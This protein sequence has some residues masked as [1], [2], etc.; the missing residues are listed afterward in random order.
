[1]IQKSTL[2]LFV[3]LAF[4]GYFHP[5]LKANNGAPAPFKSEPDS[6]H[7][8]KGVF[9]FPEITVSPSPTASAT[10]VLTGIEKVIDYDVSPAGPVVAALV[11]TSDQTY[12]IKFWKIGDHSLTDCWTTPAGYVPTAIAWHPLGDEMFVIAIKET[13]YHILRVEK[14]NNKWVSTSIF[15][16][17][18][19]LKRLVVCPRPFVT[20]YNS[21][22]RSEYYSYRIFF[23][24]SL[25]NKSFRTVS[26]TEDGTR[27]YQVIGPRELKTTF[28]DNDIPPSEMTSEYALPLTFH[29]AGHELVWED[30]Q[31]NFNVSNYNTSY[32]GE[33]KPLAPSILKGGSITATPNGLGFIHWRKDQPG[34]G[35]YL[36]TTGKEE[37]QLQDAHLITTP[38]SV[39]DGRGIVGLSKS[40]DQYTF[41]YLPVNMPLADVQNAW[42]FVR[43]SEELNLFQKNFGLFRTTSDDQL[44]QLYE[45]ENYAC[46]GYDRTVPTRPYLVTTDIFWELYASAYEGI[47]IISERDQAIPN[48]W[49]FVGAADQYYKENSKTSPWVPVFQAL[50]DLHSG[51]KQNAEVV[52][53]TEA[54]GVLKSET[55]NKEFNYAELKPRSHYTSNIEMQQYFMGFK[56]LTTVYDTNSTIMEELNQLPPEVQSYAAKWIECYQGFISPSRSPLVWKV[57]K[58]DPPRYNKNPGTNLT[59]FP[60]SWGFDNEVLYSTVYHENTPVELRV[61]G[62]GGMRLL[63]SGLDLA[64][65]LGNGLATSILHDD[66]E[67]YPPLKR[68]IGNL[69]DNFKTQA[70]VNSKNSN[71][72]DCWIN[73]LAIQWADTVRS[74]N[75]NLDKSLWQ[76]KRLQTGLASWATLRHATGLVNERSAAECGEAGFEEIILRAP[77]GYVE[78]DPFTFE[79]IADLFEATIK[80]LPKDLSIAPEIHESYE[81]AKGSLYDG[82]TKRLNEMVKTAR[83]FKVIAEKERNGQMLS[84]E[85]FVQILYIGAIAEHCFLIFK[86]LSNP[87]YAL[88]TPDPMP[89]IADVAGDKLVSYLNAAVGDPLEWDYVIPYYGRHEIV[90]GSVYS[91]YEFNS[92]QLFDDKDWRNRLKTQSFLPWIKPMITEEPLSYP[93]NS[94]Y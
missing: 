65:S 41:S 12:G 18:N 5:A 43:S 13:K 67:K 24:M 42:M 14:Q 10:I 40:G 79:A 94:G 4:I 8:V 38:S 62:P 30:G 16:S 88:S 35:M 36:L 86:S 27:F 82:I 51:N 63:P 83:E 26:T 61:E 48:F 50:S 71:L 17:S 52:R 11:K 54:Q 78:P 9:D 80:Y 66:F 70:R 73:A 44:Y 68:V 58:N 74:A 15:S 64:A 45:T 1:M 49:K 33:S 7:I 23:G 39:P 37:P 72:Y 60:L 34:I 55:L 92:N 47:F 31:H 22:S 89:K 91:Y 69:Q 6:L 93:A 19:Q 21:D 20:A 81:K 3:L 32:W 56:Y 77:R 59:M 75:N 29:P 84:A 53:I 46:G 85:E 76:L 87:D 25:D 90:K 28:P 2:I 57:V